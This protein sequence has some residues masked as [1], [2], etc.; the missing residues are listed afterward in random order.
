VSALTQA[1]VGVV[2]VGNMGAAMAHRLLDRGYA[3]TVRDIRAEAENPLVARGARRAASPAA[4]AADSDVILVVVVDAAQTRSVLFD[5]SDP[6]APA[7]RPGQ[8][9]CLQST[10]APDDTAQ[11][12][13][14]LAERGVLAVDAPISGGPARARAGTLS[15][16]AAGDAASI[17]RAAPVLEALSAR[18]FVVGER[19]GQGAAMKLVNNLLAGANLAAASEAFALGRRVGLDARTLVDVIGASS[20]QSW[21]FDDR[22]ARLLAG[23]HAPRAHTHI[24]AKD[25]GLALAMARGASAA[26]PVGDA[27]GAVFRAALERGLADEDDSALVR[28]YLDDDA[29][30]QP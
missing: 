14:R 2:G 25:V 15:I 23:D 19:P 21:I 10:I 5:G 8:C 29:P 7:L 20:G 6:A 11:I 13:A 17:A 16:M 26:T 12:A 22:F 18:L 30:G 1:R 3:V 28:L 4:L 27:A 9:V 24:L